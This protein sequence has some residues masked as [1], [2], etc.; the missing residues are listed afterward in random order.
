MAFS[1]MN[2]LSQMGTGVAAFAATAGLEAQKADLARQ[3]TIL[4]D[5]LATTRESLGRRE[6]ADIAA[7]AVDIQNTFTSGENALNRTTQLGIANIGAGATLGAAGIHAKSAAEVANIGA[8]ATTGA[9]GINAKSATDVANISSNRKPD[10][11][12][13]AEWFANATPE[14]RQAYSAALMAKAGLPA[15][16]ADQTGG[17][18]SGVADG[19]KPAPRP[20]VTGATP[21]TGAIPDDTGTTTQK[22]PGT[23]DVGADA[24]T[25]PAPT[26]LNPK[27]L[28]GIPDAAASV[29]KKMVEGRM[30][31][32]TSLAINKP[33]WQGMI[34]LASKYDPSF[35]DTTWAGRVQTRKDFTGSGKDAQAIA[36]INNALG[37]AGALMDS[38]NKLDNVGFVPAVTNPVMNA[39]QSGVFG[40]TRQKPTQQNIDALAAEARKVFSMTGSGSLAELEKWEKD[41]DINQSKPQMAASLAK[42]VELLDSRLQ[43]IGDNYNRGMQ[44]TTEPMTLL[45]EHG[46]AVYKGLTGN[47]PTNAVGYQL[48]FKPSVSPPQTIPRGGANGTATHSDNRPPLSSFFPQ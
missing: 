4:A 25:L 44:R 21:V 22:A 2:G 19:T 34:A 30:S 12:K 13:E 38:F 29:I 11:I 41:F 17:A 18:A 3:T 10:E 47:A 35:D 28:A 6:S 42:F 27:A 1:L 36:A 48:G 14:Q 46:M 23:P 40:D 45:G 5:Q 15:W 24:N 33:Y 20:P 7:K 37:H 8:N 39:I 43:A 26:N 16:M 32:P 31:P 9:A